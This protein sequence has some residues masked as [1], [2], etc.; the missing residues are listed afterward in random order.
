MKEACLFF[1]L[2][3][4]AV[5]LL[6]RWLNLGH[7]KRHGR[8]VPD[9]FAGVVDADTLRKAA[10]YTVA[11]DR[12]GMVEGLAGNLFVLVF[13]F[14]GLLPLYDGWISGGG[15][16]FFLSGWIFFAG[17][18]LLQYLLDVPF[19]LYRTFVI[20]NRFGFNTMTVRLWCSDQAKSLGV[21]MV[22][23]SLLVL[24]A[25]ALVKT[26]PGLWWFWV[27][28][29]FALVSIFLIYLSPYVIEPLFFKFREV[30][31]DDLGEKIRNLM[32]RA[33]MTVSR[34]MQVDASRRSKHSNAYFTGI[35]RVKRIVLFDTLLEQ[36]TD[37]EIL[38]VLAHEV[39]HWRL[40]HLWKRLVTMELVALGVSLAVFA[41][42]G[43]VGPKSFL[44]FQSSSFFARLILSGFL[45]SLAAFPI[46]PFSSWLS[47]RHENQ[48]DRFAADLTGDP[49]DLARGL[50]KLA[51]SNL[52]NLHPH[53]LYAWFYFSHPPVV[54]R[55]RELVKKGGAGIEKI[56]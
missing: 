17:L 45:L 48:A 32:D 15:G 6:L 25:L 12:L 34:V 54:R 2:S 31:R 11:R 33:G 22:L 43:G 50:V 18:F 26:S 29:F 7:L 46:T 39:G 16:N 4:V 44:W 1:F 55:V 23:L 20:E 21:G 27:W 47:R 3:T 52:A 9:E 24:G 56:D 19:S 5:R 30:E 35:G 37:G 14:G 10:E 49:T 28:G 51:K 53:P 36:M 40:G 13:F 38:G 41:L 8:K 42:A